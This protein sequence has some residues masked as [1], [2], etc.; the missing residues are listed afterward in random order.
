MFAAISSNVNCESQYRFLATPSDALRTS[1]VSLRHFGSLSRR[2]KLHRR[3]RP[4]D[5]RA[6]L[7]EGGLQISAEPLHFG[8]RRATDQQHA[9]VERERR[10]RTEPQIVALVA[11]A[12]T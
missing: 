12:A 11:E 8:L 7:G 1:G 2:R 6:A 5:R 4:K 10:L 9:V 3:Q